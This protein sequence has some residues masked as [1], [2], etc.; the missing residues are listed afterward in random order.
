MN[1]SPLH[2]SHNHS[3]FLYIIISFTQY[4]VH[5]IFCVELSSLT[6]F[7]YLSLLTNEIPVVRGC[8]CHTLMT[9]FKC[10]GTSQFNSILWTQTWRWT[11]TRK[12]S[13]TCT[14]KILNKQL[15]SAP[16]LNCHWSQAKWNLAIMFPLFTR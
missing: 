12:T 6:N 9:Q 5:H 10:L 16:V 15:I 13:S 2:N 7:V 11:E 1:C 3:V 4:K 8:A 14:E